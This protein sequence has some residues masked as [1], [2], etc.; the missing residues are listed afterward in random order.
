MASAHRKKLRDGARA[1]MARLLKRVERRIVGS[2]SAY[3]GLAAEEGMTTA[4]VGE[5]VMSRGRER[6]V[7]A[8]E[9]S[10]RQENQVSNREVLIDGERALMHQLHCRR[11][12]HHRQGG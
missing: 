7:A 11:V 4:I 9:E 12:Q 6:K 3:L 10:W 8:L 1:R 2:A 5:A